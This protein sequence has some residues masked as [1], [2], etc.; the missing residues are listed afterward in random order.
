MTILTPHRT[1]KPIIKTQISERMLSSGISDV[2]ITSVYS[3]KTRLKKLMMIMIII[4]RK[5]RWFLGGAR[6]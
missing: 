4:I 6:N 1:A 2:V 3:E 5:K